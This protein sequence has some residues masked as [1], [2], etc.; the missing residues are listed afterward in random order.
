[1][2]TKDFQDGRNWRKSGRCRLNDCVYVSGGL[3]AV[4]DSK[5]GYGA[6]AL[7]LAPGA[8]AALVRAVTA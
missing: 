1:M 5:G 7:R 6:P 3:D 8:I 2:I 4:R